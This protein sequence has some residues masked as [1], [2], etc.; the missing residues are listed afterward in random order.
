MTFE[1]TIKEF[2]SRHLTGMAGGLRHPA[3]LGLSF[4]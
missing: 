3:L 4:F 1:V 2:P